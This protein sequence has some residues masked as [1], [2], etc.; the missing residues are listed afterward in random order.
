L[1]AIPAQK[2]TSF[3]NVFSRLRPF[4]GR[5][6]SWAEGAFHQKIKIKSN[7]NQ[8]ELDYLTENDLS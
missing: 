8:K 4:Q 3:L 2:I 7:N 1:L 6:S 5:V